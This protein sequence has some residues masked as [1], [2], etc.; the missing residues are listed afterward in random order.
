MTTGPY[1]PKRHLVRDVDDLRRRL[2]AL[3]ENAVV[4]WD[5]DRVS[6]LHDVIVVSDPVSDPGAVAVGVLGYAVDDGRRIFRLVRDEGDPLGARWVEFDRAASA[7]ITE[8]DAR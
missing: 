1:D 7:S 8:G 2:E 4:A 6:D 3:H 5:R